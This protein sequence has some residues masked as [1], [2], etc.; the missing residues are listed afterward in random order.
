ML[1]ERFFELI[2]RLAGRLKEEYGFWRVVDA[3]V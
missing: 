2:I 3:T 1:C